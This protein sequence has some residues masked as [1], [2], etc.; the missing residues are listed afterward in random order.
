MSGLFC[1]KDIKT[2]TAQGRS[3]ADVTAGDYSDML[4]FGSY[5]F[6]ASAHA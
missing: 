1:R 4:E 2:L 5:N 6:T 3:D